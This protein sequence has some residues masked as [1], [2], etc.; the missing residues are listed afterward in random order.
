LIA[1]LATSFVLLLRVVLALAVVVTA[2]V[3]FAADS[4]VAAAARARVILF[5]GECASMVNGD[6]SC[7]DVLGNTEIGVLKN[8]ETG[9]ELSEVF[10]GR[11]SS[12]GQKAAKKV[13]SGAHEGTRCGV[14]EF[15]MCTSH[16]T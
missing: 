14:L 1:V 12:N 3:D 4:D 2:R 16:M 7:M 8:R 15:R 5:G 9:K 11:E 6:P 10:H 13:N